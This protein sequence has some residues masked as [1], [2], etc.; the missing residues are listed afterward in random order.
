MFFM[1]IFCSAT[2]AGRPDDLRSLAPTSA[3]TEAEEFLRLGQRQ[4]L[5]HSPRVAYALGIIFVAA[6]FVS[7][8]G[9][10]ATACDRPQRVHMN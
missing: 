5:E 8:S 3:D 4:V 1:R 6:I 7:R 10:L 2:V 9:L